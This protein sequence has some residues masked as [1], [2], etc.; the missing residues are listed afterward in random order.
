MFKVLKASDKRLLG[1]LATLIITIC[2]YFSSVFFIRVNVHLNHLIFIFSMRM[3][4]S[5]LIMNDYK[6]SWSSAS[7]KSYLLKTLIGIL[8]FLISLPVFFVIFKH[9]DDIL[10]MLSLEVVL[11]LIIQN[12]AMLVYRHV[13][14]TNHARRK[15]KRV[16]IYG[17][18]KAGQK[19]A[20]EFSDTVYKVKFFI[21]DNDK[22]RQRTIDGVPVLSKETFIELSESKKIRKYDLLVIAM[23]SLGDRKMIKKFFEEL[24]PYFYE[25]RILPALSDILQDRN[26]FT[27]LRNI[28]V[29]DLLARHPKDLNEV[30][31]REFIKGKRILVTGGGGS[32]GS[33]ICRQCCKY[34]A[35]QVIVLDH[36]ELDLYMINEELSCKIVVPVL[37]SVRD[38]ISLEKTF[39][40]YRP[41]IVI[42]AAAYKHVPM[43]EYNVIEGITNNIIGTKN[44]IDLSIQYKVEKFVLISTDKAVRPTNVM[45]ATKRVCEL[46]AQNSNHNGTEICAVRFGNV[47]GSS[48][49][50][51][52]KFTQQI[53]DGGPITI[54]HPE[55]TRYFMLIPEAC[56]L[57]L[58]AAS[59]GRGGE[60]MILDMGETVR[61]VDLAKNMIKLAGRPDIQIEFTGLRPGEK[62]YEELLI[63]DT[64]KRTEFESITIARAAKYDITLLNGQIMDLLACDDKI[65][66]LKEIVPEFNHSPNVTPKED[67]F[68]EH[69]MTAQEPDLFNQG[70]AVRG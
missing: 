6:L 60:V 22:V 63:D 65:A 49:S 43:V 68:K 38:I 55:I 20:E 36:S 10:R 33:E 1:V 19:I 64:D 34:G 3:A 35:E 27:Q 50:V 8:A 11:F 48:G 17:A 2:S 66:K 21:D 69:K 28:D 7:A 25:V 53:R 41:H 4:L 18:G 13:L 14:L 59:I 9:G 39:S 26:F 51:I 54:T 32:I 62:L 44:C 12:T 47:L 61:I 31:I 56:Q 70:S 29:K 46:Y 40:K 57:V 30:R 45:G 15:E 24:S 42:H 16:V 58:Q 5:F 67:Y 23:P 37:Q 52:P